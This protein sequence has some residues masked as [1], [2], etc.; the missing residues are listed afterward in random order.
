[1]HE[2]CSTI[3]CTCR[4]YDSTC[5]GS[6]ILRTKNYVGMEKLQKQDFRWR[7]PVLTT[8][9]KNFILNVGMEKEQKQ[10]LGWRVCVLPYMTD[11][12]PGGPFIFDPALI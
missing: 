4:N 6:Q 8:S 12:T 1:M 11:Y 5:D 10:E 9:N 7:V 2:E 3:K